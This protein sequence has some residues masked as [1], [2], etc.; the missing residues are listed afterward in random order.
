MPQ[1]FV[2]SEKIVSRDRCAEICRTAKAQGL[3]VGFSSGAFDLLH[4]GHVDYLIKARQLCDVLIVGVNS[5]SSIRRY[6]STNRPFISELA[7]ANVVAALECVEHVFIFDEE[8][9]NLN[10]ELIK[11]DIY[12]KAGDYTK[13]QLSS[14]PLVEAYG[15]QIK[16]IDPVVGYSTS[17]IA[18]TVYERQISIEGISSTNAEPRPAIFLDRD[19]TI[20]EEIGYLHEPDKTKLISG[21]AAAIRS[22]RAAGYYIILVT[23]QPGIGFGYFT[24]TDFFAVNARMLR[25]L[26]VEGAVVDKIY[27]CPH[28]ESEGC[29]CRKPRTGLFERA[30]SELPII[31]DRSWMVGDMTGDIQA[32]KNFGIKSALVSSGK[33]GSDARY[34]VEPDKKLSTL[35]ELLKD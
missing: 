28:N 18:R 9:N 13:S 10:I 19:G 15:G 2:L 25:L 12:F 22:F 17:E 24:R 32:A 1:N 3:R 16:L 11:P 5:D 8:N 35:E 14:A 31:K 27:F 33:A 30:C 6:K 4:V 7:R 29:N 34:N 21:V 23:N 26:S 20:V